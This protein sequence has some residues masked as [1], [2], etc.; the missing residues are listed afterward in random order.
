MP[1][2]GKSVVRHAEHPAHELGGADKAA[3][4]DANGWD[5]LPLR[6]YRVMQTA[7]RT[8]ASIADPGDDRVPALELVDEIGVGR[9]TIVRLGTP[10]D[11]GNAE[12]LTQQAI[13]VGKVAFG[14]LF[15]IRNK[16]HRLAL[17]RVRS[18][19]QFASDG[20]AL[21]GGI[22]HAQCH[23]LSLRCWLSHL[24]ARWPRPH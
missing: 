13:E 24:I 18:L 17:E 14:A 4:H 10:D 9:R 5:A 15:A 21:I 19:R 23:E 2:H 12:L 11:L 8:A 22:E 7:R 3:G 20:S 6:Y 16:T 1:D